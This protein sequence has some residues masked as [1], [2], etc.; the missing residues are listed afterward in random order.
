M[1]GPRRLRDDPDF[2]WETGCDLSEEGLVVGDYALAD[3]K[4]RVLAGAAGGSASA[5]AA[6]AAWVKGLLVS[7]VLVA[8]VGGGYLW[9]RSAIPV[10][11]V[12]A[13]PIAEVAVVAAAPPPTLSTPAVDMPGVVQAPSAQTAEEPNPQ[14]RAEAS[15]AAPMSAATPSVDAAPSARATKAVVVAPE[16]AVA[17][18]EDKA[19]AGLSPLRMELA[20][21]ERSREA[22]A[23]EDWARAEASL[24]HYLVT[25]PEGR[26]REEAKLALL[27][28]HVELGQP[29]Q[30]E[31]LAAEMLA[32]TL[33]EGRRTELA[34]I[35]AQA[36]L[37]LERC[38]EVVALLDS[39][40]LKG[41]DAGTLRKECRRR[42]AR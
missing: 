19:P 9:G 32:G 23:A 4:G 35:R 42:A 28:C 29:S 15:T 14:S 40:R 31:V 12:N 13:E 11:E 2:Q 27:Q 20:D 3:M 16:S 10:S 41:A 21:W 39:E 38:D 33:I 7:G 24:H 1:S 26:L 6:T 25:W 5:A 22:L 37:A 36:L 17:M 34:V 18:V 30:V 8:A